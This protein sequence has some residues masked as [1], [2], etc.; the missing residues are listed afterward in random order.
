VTKPAL[1][2][3]GIHK[4]FGSV[5]AVRGADFV[6]QPGELHALL[7]ENGAGK[8]T[9]MRIAAGLVRPDQ[10]QITVHGRSV[11]FRNPKD[12]REAGIGM[13]HQHFTSI[14]AFTVQDN[15][16]LSSDW[17]VHPRELSRQVGALSDRMGFRL[18]PAARAGNLTLAE[19]QRLEILKVMASDA[20]ILILDEPTGSL[21]PSEAH[22]LLG[23]VHL[24]VQS[25][26]AAVLITHKLDEAIRFADRVTVLR[27]GKVTLT[28]RTEGRTSSE[29]A[30]AMLGESLPA[31][32]RD[33]PP[34]AGEAVITADRIVVSPLKGKGPGIVEGTFQVHSGELVGIAAVEGN[35]EREL[36]R[37][38][39]GL[40]EP[41]GG[42]LTV[43]QPVSLIPEDRTTDG[44]IADFTLTENLT[45]GLGRAAPWV[46]RGIIDSQEARR[47]ATDLITSHQI[48]ASGPD[49]LASSLSGGNQQKLILARSLER[50]P[51]VLIAE[52]P[53]RGLDIRASQAAFQGLREAARQGA[54]VLVHSSDLDELLEWCDRILVVTRGRVITPPVNADSGTIGRLLL[55]VS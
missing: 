25:G 44:L 41:S 2:L 53:G 15:V 14:P 46:R 3:A 28:A 9:L 43:R 8:S 20:S 30:V 48:A 40:V 4:R 29:L 49:A 1:A 19:L 17:P 32:K 5:H 12:G 36:L 16:A 11:R 52:N 51:R 50:R 45:L 38:M 7:G 54:G 55:A 26:S 10:G 39:A 24:L 18:D 35:G 23:I 13:V 31:R 6:L 37:A 42:I 47:L 21:S 34:P 33:G 27:Q 22:E